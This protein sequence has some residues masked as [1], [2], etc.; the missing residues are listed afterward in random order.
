VLEALA[1]AAH[2]VRLISAARLARWRPHVLE[3]DARL[4]GEHDGDHRRVAVALVIVA[5]L[6]QRGIIWVAIVAAGYSLSAPQLV[7]VLSAGLVLAWISTLV[8]LG[9]GVAEG[10]NAAMF[11]LIGA[12]AALGVALALARRA[13]QV[14]FAVFG[15]AV[16]AVDR[17]TSGVFGSLPTHR[18]SEVAQ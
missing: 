10:G 5:Q 14:V 4:R 7:A 9:V 13:N 18:P 8:P 2:R 11:A 16:L 6:L 1:G 3:V 17:V 15:F 12:P